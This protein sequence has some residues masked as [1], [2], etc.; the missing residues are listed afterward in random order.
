MHALAA[1]LFAL[2]IGG[3]SLAA[4]ADPPTPSRKLCDPEKIRQTNAWVDCLQKALDKSEA[5]LS[6]LVSKIAVQM[7]AN[8]MLEEPKRD[9]NRRLF[10]ATQTKWLQL[11]DDD[12][13]SFAA[14][15]A[16]LGFGAVQFRLVCLLDETVWREQTLKQR[17]RDDLK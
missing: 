6:T 14:N 4:A 8:D 16:G 9:E 12:C 7:Q 11:R 15:H 2:L 5:G 10:E 1:L 17:Y 13:K 3:P